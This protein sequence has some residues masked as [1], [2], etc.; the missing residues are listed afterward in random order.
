MKN[1]K[2]ILW[3]ALLATAI[4][5]V[6]AQQY[7]SEKDFQIDWD[8]NG[9]VMII[10]YLGQKREV[11][12]PP[13]IQDNTVTGIGYG[14]FNDNKNITRVTIPDSVTSIVGFSGCTNLTSINIPNNVIIIG[15]S[16]FQGCTSLASIVIPNRVTRIDGYAFQGCTK[17]VN[18]TIP[19]S[20]TNI[21]SGAFAG[22]TGLTN[23]IIGKNVTSIG[24]A[25]EE[26]WMGQSGAFQGCISLT[27]IIIPDSVTS[28]E[29]ATFYGCNSLTSVII[30][31]GVKSI[32]SYAFQGCT[33]L[34]NI[35]ISNNVTSIGYAAFNNCT[36]L[37]SITIPE[38]V[39]RIEEAAFLACDSLIS[40]T[41]QGVITNFYRFSGDNPFPG[42]LVF[43]HAASDGGPGVYT[44]FAGGSTWRKT[45]S[46][47]TQPTQPTT[48]QQQATAQTTQ[49]A[50]TGQPTVQ[51]E[52]PVVN[53]MIRINGGTFTMGSPNNEPGRGEGETQ[54]Q[55][56]LDGF[57]MSKYEI[58][59]KEYQEVMGTNPSYYKGD[60]LPVENV[61]WYDA[62]EYCNKR[63]QKE[64]LTAAYTING[65]RVT[66]NLKANG[67]RLPT[68]AEWEY[69]C[70]AGTTTAFNNGNNNAAS[71][72][73]IAWYKSNSGNRTRQ[74]GLKTPNAWGLY[75]MHGN[76]REWCWDW[77]GNYS[78]FSTRNPTGPASG[79]RRVA[80]GGDLTIEEPRLLR[81]AVRLSSKPDEKFANIG[82][83]V[84][85]L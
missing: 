30:G 25:G 77:A 37:T 46:I 39:T 63:S 49:P 29:R 52:I 85:R 11:S 70:R 27:S 55:V 28:I 23:V 8:N 10:K 81:S 15:G 76:V 56:T 42:D 24:G 13:K 20:V 65:N 47:S 59:Q 84:V 60:N 38:S 79:D 22:C 7:D 1:K 66:L 34:T 64:G 6:Y 26:A 69:A 48:T 83:R 14:A 21:G 31:S 33:K 78:I 41:F 32:G 45:Q 2:T 19:D 35:T 74:V 62:I 75:D 80:R 16:A 61:T 40:V 36:N 5:P 57:Y 82:F 4:I 71:L 58:T 43:K 12:I 54:H 67:Y 44:R 72:D 68:E 3:I 73:A 17:L 50:T 53:S 18:I 51:P 9:G